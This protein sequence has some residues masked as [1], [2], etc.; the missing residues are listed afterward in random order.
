MRQGVA[1]EG[2]VFKKGEAILVLHH[3]LGFFT[4]G[5]F[6]FELVE[7]VTAFPVGGKIATGFTAQHKAAEV[8]K[9]RI[10]G[11]RQGD[12]STPGPLTFFTVVEV[13]ASQARVPV[14]A[15]VEAASRSHLGKNL[16]DR[17]STRL[18][19]S[20]VRISYAV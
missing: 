16:V 3:F 8:V 20:H 6:V 14:G 19:S 15:E 4:K 18:N 12:G 7:L 11:G 2:T 9:F 13:H 5:K 1:V 10:D 17:K